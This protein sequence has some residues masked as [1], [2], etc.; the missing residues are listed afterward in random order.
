MAK[1][2]VPPSQGKAA[3]VRPGAGA[4]T[5]SAGASDT[6]QRVR[7]PSIVSFFQESRAEL[8]KVTWPTRQET[9]NLTIAVVAM[10]VSIA[11]F[12]GLIDQLLTFVVKP[13][14]GTQ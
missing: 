9:T 5:R 4:S 12:L 10:T 2:V 6:S 11:A 14:I 13:I 3:R 1:Q 8:K 7:G